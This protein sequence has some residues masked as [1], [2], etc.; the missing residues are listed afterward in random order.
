MLYKKKYSED[1]AI[2]IETQTYSCTNNEYKPKLATINKFFDQ[3]KHRKIF[4]QIK[5]DYIDILP[6]DWINFVEKGVEAE[7]NFFNMQYPSEESLDELGEFYIYFYSY[8]NYHTNKKNENIL[9]LKDELLER[10]LLIHGKMGDFD[11]VFTYY[12][13]YI[14]YLKQR[15]VLDGDPSHYTKG[16]LYKVWSNYSLTYLNFSPF[17][18]K[19]D[20][21]LTYLTSR[22]SDNNGSM[23]DTPYIDYY[24]LRELI[25]ENKIAE[26]QK[27]PENLLSFPKPHFYDDLYKKHQKNIVQ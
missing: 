12:L 11:L 1:W 7:N 15:L 17:V 19:N 3:Y 8:L 4:T 21:K 6:G 25:G 27:M 22:K 9:D 20:K 14:T 5:N 2:Q 26:I 24:K 10:Y 23:V 13:R 18:W 16:F